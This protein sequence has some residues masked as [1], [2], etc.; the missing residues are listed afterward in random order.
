MCLKSATPASTARR[1]ASSSRTAGE[2]FAVRNSGATAVVEGVGDHG[3]EYMTGG[4]IV[5]LGGTGKNFGAGMTGGLAYILDLENR[6][7]ALYNPAL[8]VVEPLTAEDEIAVQQL[9]YG[10]LEN[11]ESA[12]AREIL[13]A[14]PTFVG[15]FRKVRPRPP[16]AKPAEAKPPATTEAVISENVVAVQP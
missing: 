13:G 3:C 9:V 2:R 16:A 15:H 12:R 6:F 14:W 7:E 10:H 4:T 11:T 8:I 1:A 5:V